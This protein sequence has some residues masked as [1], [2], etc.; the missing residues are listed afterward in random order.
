M[1]KKDFRLTVEKLIEWCQRTE[2]EIEKSEREY[3]EKLLKDIKEALE[4]GATKPSPCRKSWRDRF[5]R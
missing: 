2:Q 5:S 3:R 4:R 1:N